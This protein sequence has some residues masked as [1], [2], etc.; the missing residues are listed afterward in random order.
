MK[1]IKQYKRLTLWGKI[2][3]WGSIASIVA[4]AIALSPLGS[5]LVNLM[6]DTITQEGSIQTKDTGYYNVYYPIPFVSPPELTW[7]KTV[8]GPSRRD[9][10]VVE[11]R[12]DGFRIHVHSLFSSWT[13]DILWRAKGR[14]NR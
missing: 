2:G 5:Y 10:T 1:V 7:P 14:K 6:T 8:N 9:F 4:L 13:D 12:S 11:Q 3:I